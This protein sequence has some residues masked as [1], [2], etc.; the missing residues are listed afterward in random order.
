MRLVFIG[1]MVAFFS[2]KNDPTLI[3]PPFDSSLIAGRW[4]IT[5]AMRKNR[6]TQTINGAILEISDTTLTHNMYGQDSTYSI[7]WGSNYLISSKDT[8]FIEKNLDSLLI[9]KCV[10]LRH[11]FRLS[12]KRLKEVQGEDL[13]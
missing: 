5:D 1:L 6:T 3:T 7:T 8:F 13:E 9:L 4:V 10:L 12:L 2:C 11:P